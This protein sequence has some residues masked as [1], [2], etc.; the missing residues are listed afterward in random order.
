M[1]PQK[2]TAWASV[3]DQFDAPDTLAMRIRAEIAAGSWAF[4]SSPVFVED[5][6]FEGASGRGHLLSIAGS[7]QG[8]K[9]LFRI[10]LF[11]GKGRVLRLDAPV[12][13]DGDA[14][15]MAAQVALADAVAA[16]MRELE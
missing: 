3:K 15:A 1:R 6:F 12:L 13:D 8:Q 16:T 2:L 10:Y 7:S 4:L 5:R 9:F 14:A 11:A